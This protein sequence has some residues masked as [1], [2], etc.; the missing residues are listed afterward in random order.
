M[1]VGVGVLHELRKLFSVFPLSFY[2]PM[3]LL[4]NYRDEGSGASVSLNK[5]D[6]H[7]V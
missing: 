3:M 7:D 2:V 6:D 1:R 5:I 4:S